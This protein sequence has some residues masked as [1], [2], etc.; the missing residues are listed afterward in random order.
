[1]TINDLKYLE[2]AEGQSDYA[3]Y[4]D[5]SDKD[6]E[7]LIIKLHEEKPYFGA[8][9]SQ[10]KLRR[11]AAL[12]FTKSEEMF[13]TSLSL[14]QSTSELI[15]RHLAKRF[16]NNWT[17]ADLGC[18]LG[19]NTIFL[20]ESV[21]K[22]IAADLDEIK[23]ACAQHNAGVYGVNDKI[24]FRIGDA[25]NNIDTNIDAFFLDPARDRDGK[26]KTRSLLNS[27]P[28]L[29]DILPKL[30]AVTKNVAV[31][32]S[33]AFDYEELDLLPE[34]P[35]VEIISEDNNCKVAMLWFGDFKQ[36]KRLATC[37]YKDGVYTV[38]GD[39]Q[40]KAA[41]SNLKKYLY[42][43]N[44]A[45]SKAHLV[46]KLAN[47]FNLTKIDFNS[48]YLTS[49]NLVTDDFLGAMR[50]FEII[51]SGEF[52]VK[53]LQKALKNKKINQTEIVVKNLKIT[54]DDLR[55]R[56]KLKEGGPYLVVILNL[57]EKKTYILLKKV[58]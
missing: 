52:S 43:P 49:D 13:F 38:T 27:S 8:L 1:M 17:V 19:A 12:K 53:K 39:G 42:E 33:P 11:R 55:G 20:A 10:I 5:F 28:N 6:L 16:Q 51:E 47:Q 23:I 45:I 29:L 35:E 7:V 48:S 25:N 9:V 57:L 50:R 34:Q 46:N 22:V 58:D 14:E 32:I 15:A 37:F 26:T 24:E 56:L 30:F 41:V 36:T 18:G 21:K 54:S 4:R 31:K 40:E 44:K 3:K 2:S